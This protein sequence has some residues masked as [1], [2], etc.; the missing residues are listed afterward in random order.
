LFFIQEN[1]YQVAN[2][3]LDCFSA[4]GDVLLSRFAKAIKY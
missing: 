2:G 4:G 1:K 3:S